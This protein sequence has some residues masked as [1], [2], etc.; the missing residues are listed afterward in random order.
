M[1]Q[2]NDMLRAQPWKDGK[3]MDYNELQ[4]S[5]PVSDG[6]NKLVILVLVYEWSR[7]CGACKMLLSETAREFTKTLI[8][9]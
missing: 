1:K 9:I 7:P 5:L 2:C 8:A 6:L 3:K 4:V